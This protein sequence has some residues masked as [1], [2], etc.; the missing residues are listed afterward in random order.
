[1]NQKRSDPKSRLTEGPPGDKPVGRV[2]SGTEAKR[3]APL[4]SS[5]GADSP[6]KAVS[7]TG[8]TREKKKYLMYANRLAAVALGLAAAGAITLRQTPCRW[9][10]SAASSCG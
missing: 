7:V 10:P 6:K 5:A 9:M 2:P 8:E 4:L 3:A 1:M